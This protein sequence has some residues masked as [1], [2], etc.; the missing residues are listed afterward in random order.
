MAGLP[1]VGTDIPHEP[2]PPFPLFPRFPLFP[3]VLRLAP[4]VSR[5]ARALSQA[6]LQGA[7]FRKTYG[8]LGNA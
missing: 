5:S 3:L 7:T 1:Q 8:S 6:R 2:S 4:W